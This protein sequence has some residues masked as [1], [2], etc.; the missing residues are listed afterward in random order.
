MRIPGRKIW[1]AFK[2]LDQFSDEQC[3]RFVRAA[4]AFGW[5]AIIRGVALFLIGASS[6][7]G[8]LWALTEF[9]YDWDRTFRPAWLAIPT[10]FAAWIG[11]VSLSPLVVLVIRD[12]ILR[13]RI[14]HLLRDRGVCSACRYSLIGLP[15]GADLRVACPECGLTTIVD[16][17]LGEL[18]LDEAG[19]AKF[20]PRSGGIFDRP[21][22]WTPRR[23]RLARRV[24]ISMLAISFGGPLLLWSAYE[25][26]L[27]YQA[28]AARNA[29]SPRAAFFKLLADAKSHSDGGDQVWAA[30]RQSLAAFDQAAA[31][32]LERLESGSNA[33]TS[34]EYLDPAW[35]QGGEGAVPGTQNL[36]EDIKSAALRGRS[37]IR[38]TVR[39]ASDIR[40]ILSP[41][42]AV[43]RPSVS[44]LPT[45]DP[46]Q[47]LLGASMDFGFKST[48]VRKF[49]SLCAS[50]MS[51]AARDGRWD[52]YAEVARELRL[53]RDSIRLIPTVIHVYVE[54][55]VDAVLLEQIRDDLMRSPSPQLIKIASECAA[56]EPQAQRFLDAIEVERLA[57]IDLMQWFFSDPSRVRWERW[58]KPVDEFVN[59]PN[60]GWGNQR[61]DGRLGSFWENCRAF[62]AAAA[63]TSGRIKASPPMRPQ[64]W[65]RP[66]DLLFVNKQVPDQTGER[67]LEISDQQRLAYRSLRVLIEIQREFVTTGAYPASL[68]AVRSRLAP[69]DLENPFMAGEIEYRP[70]LPLAGRLISTDSFLARRAFVDPLPFLLYAPTTEIRGGMDMTTRNWIPFRLLN[71]SSGTVPMVMLNIGREGTSLWYE[72]S[73]IG[74]STPPSPF[75]ADQNAE[76]P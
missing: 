66:S 53:L 55:G 60:W 61:V 52:D 28:H 51:A 26:F 20:A 74:S 23:K 41:W 1:R 35:N 6:L 75:R 39:D 68:D 12:W 27:Q 44:A 45:V 69:S 29:P 57:H 13:R 38:A 18:V 4:T 42:T 7:L 59:P 11:G 58:S 56:E 37:I 5:G 8:V 72:R 32:R 63:G 76:G 14:H 50:L 24:A 65:A 3:A 15:V 34:L 49:A 64:C 17:S 33:T 73:N 70:L 47:P 25:A 31:A 43:N 2:E 48:D 46:D 62:D 67:L 30:M 10:T 16:Q 40:A 36:S 54:S 9:T 22:F 71:A 21:P 19:R